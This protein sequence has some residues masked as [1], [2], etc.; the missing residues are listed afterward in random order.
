MEKYPKIYTIFKRDENNRK[1]VT[2][3]I[4]DQLEIK[5]LNLIRDIIVEEKVDGTNA[6]LLLGY[7]E[8]DIGFYWR[9][10]SRNNEIRE[11][12]IMYIRDTLDKVVDFKLLEEWY[13]KNFVQIPKKDNNDTYFPEIR[14]FGEVYGD[15]IQKTNYLPKGERD[16]V[17]FDI[18]INQSWLSIKVRNEIC[19]NLNLKIVPKICILDRFPSFEECYN[20]LAVKYPKSIVAEKNGLEM[21]LEGFI[22]RP[23]I[24]LYVA[25]NRRI[26]GKIKRKDFNLDI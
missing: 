11:I 23:K 7:D 3:L 24:N 8:K 22:L 10:F 25:P 9:Y 14:I 26:L 13:L 15:K 1:L 2:P 19:R 6:C 12:D 4:N 18:K 21:Y 5:G 20:L 17:V 16:F